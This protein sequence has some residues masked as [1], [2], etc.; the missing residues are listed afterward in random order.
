MLRCSDCTP[1][2][3][4][5]QSSGVD[6]RMHA[7]S[8]AGCAVVDLDGGQPPDAELLAQVL[9]LGELHAATETTPVNGFSRRAI[10]REQGGTE[11][12]RDRKQATR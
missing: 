7:C 12:T 3:E 6:P 11:Q 4:E 5:K 1:R 10:D 8:P 9:V 2:F